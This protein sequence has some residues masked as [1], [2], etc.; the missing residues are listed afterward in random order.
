MHEWVLIRL[1]GFQ[2]LGDFFNR[3]EAL[4]VVAHRQTLDQ[5][6]F[7]GVLVDIAPAPR[8]VQQA[9]HQEDVFVDGAGQIALLDLIAHPRIQRVVVQFVKPQRAD[10]GAHVF[11]KGLANDFRPFAGRFGMGVVF[12]VKKLC[13][14]DGGF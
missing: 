6:I 11:V 2:H 5:P 1:G 3:Q 8:E 4:L 7:A 13:Q 12:G 9:V 14:R 10:A